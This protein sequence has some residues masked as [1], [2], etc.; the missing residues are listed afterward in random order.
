MNQVCRISQIASKPGRHGLLPVS[1][2]T[3]WRWVRKNKFPQPIRLSSATCVWRLADIERW[4]EQRAQ[5][6][7]GKRKGTR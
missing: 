3:I 6:K 2:A 1:R 5:P 7:N 4:L